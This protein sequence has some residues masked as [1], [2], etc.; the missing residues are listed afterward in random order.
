VEDRWARADRWSQGAHAAIGTVE[1]EWWLRMVC[2]QLAEESSPG[3]HARLRRL[4]RRAAKQFRE[5]FGGRAG[6]IGLEWTRRP[7]P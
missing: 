6:S 2:G 1:P 3:Q 4:V 7:M 5:R